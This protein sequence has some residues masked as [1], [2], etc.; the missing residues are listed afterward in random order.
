MEFRIGRYARRQLAVRERNMANTNVGAWG[1]SKAVSHSR[2]SAA[3][4]SESALNSYDDDGFEFPRTH[5]PIRE[6]AS[7]SIFIALLVWV[8][9]KLLQAIF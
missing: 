2:S 7:F 6:L 9:S 4:E 8:G 5:H 1:H 3:I